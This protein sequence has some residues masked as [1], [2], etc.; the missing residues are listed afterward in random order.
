MEQVS[1]K[2]FIALIARLIIAGA[3]V[4][5]AL[6]KIMAPLDFAVAVS[7]FRLLSP[8]MTNWVAVLLP[9]L[10]LITA[11]GLLTPWL[12]RASGLCIGLMLSLFITLHLYAWMLG[13]NIDCGCFGKGTENGYPNYLWAVGRNIC[14]LLACGWIIVIDLGSGQQAKH[15]QQ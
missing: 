12:R 7:G 3:F 9:W 11:I 15:A 8:V 6:P 10:E 14:L 4:W 5:A 13:L 1:L 2:Y